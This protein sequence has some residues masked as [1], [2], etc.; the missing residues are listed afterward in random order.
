MSYRPLDIDTNFP[1]G[2]IVKNLPANAGDVGDA[3]SI[4]GSG[5]S[6]GDLVFLP[7]NSMDR[8]A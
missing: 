7:G 4:L 8:G 5:R 1:G 3:G 2:S 6:F